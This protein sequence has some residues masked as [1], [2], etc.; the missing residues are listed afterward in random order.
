M[1]EQEMARMHMQQRQYEAARH[2]M[3]RQFARF[4]RMRRDVHAAGLDL[5]RVPLLW[6]RQ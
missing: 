3:G 1:M 6:Y 5:G 2:R 4:Q